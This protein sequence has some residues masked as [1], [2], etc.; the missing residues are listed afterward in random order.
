VGPNGAGK[1]NLLKLMTEEL[2][3]PWMAWFAGIITSTC[4]IPPAPYRNFV[5]GHV[6]AGLHR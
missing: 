4:P 1:S 2:V 5:I 6:C 3:H